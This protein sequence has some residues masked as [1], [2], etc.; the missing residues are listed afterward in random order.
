MNFVDLV[1]FLGFLVGFFTVPNMFFGPAAI[2]GIPMFLV[3][4][5]P[6]SLWFSKAWVVIFI[7]F[8]LGPYVFSVPGAKAAKQMTFL[9]FTF[10]ALFCYGLYAYECFNVPVIAALTGTNFIL[11][12]LHLYTVLPDQAGE[13]ML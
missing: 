5:D 9:Y 7:I 4:L 6:I 11:F 8:V 2:T 12:C 1:W 3:D 10:V 13:A